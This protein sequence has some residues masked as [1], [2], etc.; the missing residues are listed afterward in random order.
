MGIWKHEHRQ[1]HIHISSQRAKLSLNDTYFP[2]CRGRMTGG[3]DI[4][5]LGLLP[6]K[7]KTEI[8]LHVNL[9]TLKKVRTEPIAL[10]L[11]DKTLACIMFQK[12]L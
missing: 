12:L 2:F 9:E 6:D 8:A 5:S 11:S 10:L 7:L 4:N 3:G 1:K